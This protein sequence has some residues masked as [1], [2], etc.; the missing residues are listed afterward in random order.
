MAEFGIK[1]PRKPTLNLEVFAGRPVRVPTIYISTIAG[2][3]YNKIFHDLGQPRARSMIW[4]HRK[5]EMYI[6]HNQ[7]LKNFDV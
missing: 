6:Q 5:I 4:R 7:Q 2:L 3:D 1:L